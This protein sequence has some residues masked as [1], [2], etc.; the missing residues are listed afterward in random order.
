VNTISIN[1]LLKSRNVKHINY[2]SLDVEGLELQILKSLDFSIYRVDYMT[3]EHGNIVKYQREINDYLLSVGFRL[4]RN[5]KWDDE[6]KYVG[7]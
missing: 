1:D 5:N 7:K 4:V 3:V 2:L 6:Y